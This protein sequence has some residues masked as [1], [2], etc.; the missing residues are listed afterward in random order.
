M[1]TE[2]PFLLLT[3]AVAS[4]IAFV[5]VINALLLEYFK[6][7]HRNPAPLVAPFLGAVISSMV[8]V[9]S[10][11]QVFGFYGLVAY[12]IGI[13]FVGTLAAFLWWNFKREYT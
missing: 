5:T 3:A 13:P 6:S 4:L 8:L 2:P 12:W 10:G 11:L 9:S 7:V 1:G